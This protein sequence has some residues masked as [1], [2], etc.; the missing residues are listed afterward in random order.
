MDVHT[1]LFVPIYALTSPL[2]SQNLLVGASLLTGWVWAC[3]CGED[4]GLWQA[5]SGLVDEGRVGGS[6][7]GLLLTSVSLKI[8]FP[9]DFRSYPSFVGWLLVLVLV[10]SHASR[11]HH[12]T[13]NSNSNT[14]H[15]KNPNKKTTKVERPTRTR[16]CLRT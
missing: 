13:F 2:E 1:F 15:A 12:P 16:T 3:P 11:A 4:A 10:I 8:H 7:P 6:L 5:N 14:E 9:R